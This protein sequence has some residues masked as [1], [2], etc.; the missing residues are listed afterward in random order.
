MFLL[1]FLQ[2]LTAQLAPVRVSMGLYA[3][4]DTHH[5]WELLLNP[6]LKKQTPS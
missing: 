5:A 4:G 1:G 6:Q 3:L 2:S